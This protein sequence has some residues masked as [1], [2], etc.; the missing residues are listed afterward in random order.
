MDDGSEVRG[1]RTDHPCR[2]GTPSRTSADAPC[3]SA[4]STQWLPASWG[5][6]QRPEDSAG[7]QRGTTRRH[8]TRKRRAKGIE[9]RGK[10]DGTNLEHMERLELDVPALIPQKVHHHLEI[11]LVRDVAG[12][13]RVVSAVEEDLAEELDRLA[14]CDVVG[15][16]DQGGVGGEEL[17]KI[18]WRDTGVS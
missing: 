13:D 6:R 14:L 11:G 7:R 9:K 2:Y 4:G 3:F 12:H 18:G 5:S 1:R 8:D 17:Q 10:G 16:E 15:G